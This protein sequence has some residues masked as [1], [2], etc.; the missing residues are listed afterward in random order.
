MLGNKITGAILLFFLANQKRQRNS[1][2]RAHHNRVAQGGGRSSSGGSGGG[3]AAG[4]EGGVVVGATPT[5]PEECGT[6][7]G[8]ASKVFCLLSA[9]HQKCIF[10]LIQKYQNS[11]PF[12]MKFV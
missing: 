8:K 4:S 1:R 6:P 12:K 10:Y 2:R 3:E 7:A 9:Y 5:G 11:V